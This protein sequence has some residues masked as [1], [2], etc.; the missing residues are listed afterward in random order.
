MPNRDASSHESEATS[1]EISDHPDLAAS[2]WE[3]AADIHAADGDAESAHADNLENESPPDPARIRKSRCKAA[4]AYADAAV[5]YASAERTATA[6]GDNVRAARAKQNAQKA[7]RKALEWLEKCAGYEL[8]AGELSDRQI[9]IRYNRIAALHDLLGQPK[10]AERVRALLKRIKD[11]LRKA[12]QEAAR[13][14]RE[15]APGGENS[16]GKFKTIIRPLF[17]VSFR[18]GKNAGLDWF[19]SAHV[20]CRGGRTAAGRHG[21]SSG[22]RRRDFAGVRDQIVKLRVR[23]TV[24]ITIR[25]GDSE[26]RIDIAPN[27]YLFPH[28]SFSDGVKFNK[29]CDDKCDCTIDQDG[30]LCATV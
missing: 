21:D 30:F 18:N 13:E 24:P 2:E 6:A 10:E 1:F 25:R 12:E 8:E 3:K 26:L 7:A 23:V 29:F 16:P 20:T 17:G 4:Q 28:Q 9:L 5:D 15:S 14:A 19:R 11:M 22:R 27:F